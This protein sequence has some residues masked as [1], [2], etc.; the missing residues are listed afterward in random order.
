MHP[1][2]SPDGASVAYAAAATGVGD[3]GVWTQSFASGARTL[4]GPGYRP[5]WAPD[6]SAVAFNSG[7][8][9][10]VIVRRV[11]GTWTGG[12]GRRD[13]RRRKRG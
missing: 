8:N 9:T 3:L 2:V 1:E 6:G 11:D 5:V 7:I 10:D 12:T 4:L 13:T